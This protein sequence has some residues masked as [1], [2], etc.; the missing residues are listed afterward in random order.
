MTPFRMF[1]MTGAKSC[2]KTYIFWPLL[3][4][5]ISNENLDPNNSP[6]PTFLQDYSVVENDLIWF[7][8][9]EE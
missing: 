8:S 6:V 1:I 2:A 7:N 4:A 3:G 5:P 9:I